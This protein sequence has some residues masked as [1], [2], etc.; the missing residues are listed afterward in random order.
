MACPLALRIPAESVDWLTY[1][2]L[3]GVRLASCLALARA[4]MAHLKCDCP[5]GERFVFTINERQRAISCFNHS[6]SRLDPGLRKQ[7]YRGPLNLYCDW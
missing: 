6:K 7:G 5:D 2:H 3:A 1:L 4:F